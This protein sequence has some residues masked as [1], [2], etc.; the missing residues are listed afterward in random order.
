MSDEAAPLPSQRALHLPREV[1]GEDQA[2]LVEWLVDEGGPV[3]A[4]Q[5]VAEFETTKLVFEV[6]S[7]ADGFLHRLVETGELVAV[8]QAFARLDPEPQQPAAAGAAAR[9]ASPA[10]SVGSGSDVPPPLFTRKARRLIEEHGLAAESFAG[11]SLVRV[12][13]VHRLLAAGAAATEPGGSPARSGGLDPGRL[14]ERPAAGEETASRPASTASPSRGRPANDSASSPQADD[15]LAV[16]LGRVQGLLASLQEGMRTRFDRHVP[17]GTLLNDRW[18]L[19]RSL[20]FGEASSIYDECL[21][22][23]DVV[24]GS[25]C[26]VGPFTVLDGAHAPLVIGDYTS[27]GTGSQ[28]YTHDTIERT[29]S[30]SDAPPRA[31]PTTI[32]R[33][34]FISPLVIIGPGT[35]L[36]DHCF[37]AA[38]SYVQGEFPA[39][40]YIAGNP[41]RRVGRV[42]LSDGRVVL[43]PDGSR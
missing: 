12:E 27:V 37:V 10:P 24:V 23:G 2:T 4:G 19:A 11:L 31:R 41:A 35:V 3:R 18:S 38:A 36:G 29:L 20:G 16:A 8:G 21:V 28:L 5:A 30:G 26:W 6:E 32:G 17:V 40:S 7:T 22:L 33:C 13:P 9:S 15:R 14:G 1:I 34:C 25:H 42:E 43:K 39:Y